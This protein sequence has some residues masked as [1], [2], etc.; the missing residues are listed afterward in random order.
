MILFSDAEFTDVVFIH[1]TDDDYQ[2]YQPYVTA[3]NTVQLA[4]FTD[5]VFIHTTNN[6]YQRY[7]PY[8]T[9]QNTVQLAEF[10]DVVFIHITDNDAMPYS[11]MWQDCQITFLH[12]RPCQVELSVGRQTDGRSTLS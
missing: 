2:R 11:D 8:V 9:A 4:E 12:T 1:I 6:D 3:Q 7:Q 5:V 10:T